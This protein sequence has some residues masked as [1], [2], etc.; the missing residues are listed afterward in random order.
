MRCS[1][2]PRGARRGRRSC[3]RDRPGTRA[4]SRTSGSTCSSRRA[5]WTPPS[6]TSSNVVG[7]G[8]RPGD[9][10]GGGRTLH[11]PRRRP[12]LDSGSLVSTNGH[13][14][15]EVLRAPAG[16]ALAPIRLPRARLPRRSGRARTARAPRRARRCADGRS[17]R[18]GS[19]GAAV[20]LDPLGQRRILV[21][22]LDAMPEPGRQ[23]RRRAARATA[24]GPTT[25]SRRTSAIPGQSPA[26]W[27]RQRWPRLQAMS[28]TAVRSKIA[29]ELAVRGRHVGPLGRVDDQPVDEV[30]EP[31][32]RRIGEVGPP[33]PAQEDGQVGEQERGDD[34][35]G[36]DRPAPAQ[37][38]LEHLRADEPLLA[39]SWTKQ[40]S[41][42]LRVDRVRAGVLVGEEQ[43]RP[44]RMPLGQPGERVARGLLPLRRHPREVREHARPQLRPLAGARRLPERASWRSISPTDVSSP[45]QSSSSVGRRARPI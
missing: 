37:P 2:T 44:R 19:S 10:R 3:A 28:E 15:E 23:P 35:R 43:D 5:R 42:T 4:A 26:S 32:E 12:A 13:L 1:R 20:D 39:V 33:A 11:R 30:D 25:R 34:A 45:V 36:R 9:R 18:G 41:E 21:L 7:H 8:R 17:P 24:H 31:A 27:T 38:Q 29:G 6:T 16:P 40:R 14:H 22:E